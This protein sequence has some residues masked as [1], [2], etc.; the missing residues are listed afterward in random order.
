LAGI[1]PIGCSL[2]AGYCFLNIQ[3]LKDPVIPGKVHLHRGWLAGFV[4]ISLVYLAFVIVLTQCNSN[5]GEYD[6]IIVP[7]LAVIEL[8]LGVA[9]MEGLSNMALFHNKKRHFQMIINNSAALL[10]WGGKCAS[11]Y[12]HYLQ[13]RI[14]FNY[15][16][17]DSPLELY[18]T[19][20]IERAIQYYEGYWNNDFNKLTEGSG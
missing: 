8:I 4:L 2:L 12:R 10:K 5:P 1:A 17:P 11:A 15:H 18:R 19:P 6:L 16:H 3:P 7:L 14:L 20:Q 13:Y 9:A